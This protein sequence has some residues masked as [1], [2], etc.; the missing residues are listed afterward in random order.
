MAEIEMAVV[1]C[2]H[3]N[4]DNRA[5]TFKIIVESINRDIAILIADKNM[6]IQGYCSILTKHTYDMVT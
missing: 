5:S 3:L 4:D 2:S 1:N 6:D